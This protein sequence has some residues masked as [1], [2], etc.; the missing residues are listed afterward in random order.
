MPGFATQ[1]SDD[2][3][4][5]LITYIRSDFSDRPAWQNV[6]RDVRSARQTLTD[7]D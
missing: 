6:A 3:L 5:A 2:Q 7:S 1:L 4:A